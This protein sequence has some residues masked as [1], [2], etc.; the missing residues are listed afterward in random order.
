MFRLR[1]HL[2]DWKIE[3]Q[4]RRHVG[5]WINDKDKARIRAYMLVKMAA[6]MRRRQA[7]HSRIQGA[8]LTE[9]SSTALSIRKPAKV[10]FVVY[11]QA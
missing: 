4:S 2:A 6:K 1:K 5:Y 8:D 11:T 3:V 7:Y 10:R 9:C